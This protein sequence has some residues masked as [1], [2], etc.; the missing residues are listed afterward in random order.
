MHWTASL[1]VMDWW[2]I[3]TEGAFICTGTGAIYLW[4]DQI[5]FHLIG[6]REGSLIF[7]L[8]Q[9]GDQTWFFRSKCGTIFTSYGALIINAGLWHWKCHVTKIAWPL[10]TSITAHYSEKGPEFI[11]CSEKGGPDFSNAVKGAHTFIVASWLDYFL[12]T[13]NLPNSLFQKKHNFLG[14]FHFGNSRPWSATPGDN[15]QKAHLNEHRLLTTAQN[16]IF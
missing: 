16:T 2:R 9:R 7:S 8:G 10:V 14:S 13:L 1:L 5:F 15:L 12:Q 4:E 6:Q 3:Y 11:L